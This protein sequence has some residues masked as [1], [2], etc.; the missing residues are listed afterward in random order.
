MFNPLMERIVLELG[1]SGTVCELGNQRY[2]GRKGYKSV[3]AF[4]L[5]NGY[6]S[7]VALDVN[8]DM[9]AI[10]YDLNHVQV[11]DKTYDLVTNNGT[12]E[13]VFN[14]AAVFENVH[15]LC[16]DGGYMIHVQPFTP[17]LNHGFY[18]FNPILF[19][20]LAAANDYMVHQILL[21]ERNGNAVVVPDEELYT[22]KHAGYIKGVI[23]Q[24]ANN[25]SVIAIFRKVGH[26]PFRYPIQGE[27]QSAV[28]DNN[29]R[30]E[31]GL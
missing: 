10:I 31:Y 23:R 22:E 15:S 28:R 7:Y 6:D 16:K 21:G 3:K 24:L 4:Y 25:V 8:T 29:L 18:N 2:G 30:G 26:E 17:W 14:Q 9:D 13:H 19:R 1:H 27:Y 5:D 11:P 12:G 20:D